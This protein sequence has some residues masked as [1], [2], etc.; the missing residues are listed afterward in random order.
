MPSE[1]LLE[2]EI[3]DVTGTSWQDLIDEMSDN[4]QSKTLKDCGSGGCST[5]PIACGCPLSNNYGPL[6][7]PD[8]GPDGPDFC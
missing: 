6:G 7:V 2:L 3:E 1:A 5:S 4:N 8:G